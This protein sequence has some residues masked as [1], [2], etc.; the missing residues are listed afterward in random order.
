M[1]DWLQ[2][3]QSRELSRREL[4]H[5]AKGTTWKDHKYIDKKTSGGNVRYV[6]DSPKTVYRMAE[7]GDY[8][9]KKKPGYL[10]A[11]DGYYNTKTNT[12]VVTDRYLVEDPTLWGSIQRKANSIVEAGT[13][14]INSIFQDAYVTSVKF[15]STGNIV[16]ATETKVADSLIKRGWNAIKSL[17][18]KK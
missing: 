17:F 15:D 11:E 14:I 10:I 8:Y 9:L 16:E 4:L 2:F 18:S 3:K 12:K 13:K 6:Y 1:P 5:S 7:Q